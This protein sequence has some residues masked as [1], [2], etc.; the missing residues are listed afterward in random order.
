MSNEIGDGECVLDV[1]EDVLR[2]GVLDL[3]I[4]FIISII[5]AMVG[6]FNRMYLLEEMTP[7]LVTATLEPSSF[8][9]T[10]PIEA[11]DTY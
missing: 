10:Y 3:I 11:S 5:I 7:L 6:L 1:T 4:I 2:G 8:S 9:A